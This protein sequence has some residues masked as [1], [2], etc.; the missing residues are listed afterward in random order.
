MEISFFRFY[1]I[2]TKP[3]QQL[4]FPLLQVLPYI[5]E[6]FSPTFE[7]AYNPVSQLNFK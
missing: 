6:H 4:L 5:A 2:A 7:K 1:K 3:Y